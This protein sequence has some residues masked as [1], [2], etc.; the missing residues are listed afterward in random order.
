MDTLQTVPGALIVRGVLLSILPEVLIPGILA[1]HKMNIFPE[2][3]QLEIQPLEQQLLQE[4][5][6]IVWVQEKVI[7]IQGQDP[8]AM[9]GPI[10]QV[11]LMIHALQL[12]HVQALEQRAVDTVVLIIVTQDLPVQVADILPQVTMEDLHQEAIIIVDP[13]QVVVAIHRAEVVHQV[14]VILHLPDLLPVEAVV[15][16]PAEAVQAEA[17]DNSGL[18][19]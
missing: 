12:M 4:V 16:V 13:G 17:V 15:D 18:F 10:L 11:P 2:P 3:E 9:A 19:R 6:P 14:V 8:P 1:E 7:R 5:V